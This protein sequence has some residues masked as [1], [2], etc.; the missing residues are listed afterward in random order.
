MRVPNFQQQ[1]AQNQTPS[2]RVQGGLSAG[3]AANMAESMY[4]GLAQGVK[5]AGNAYLDYHDEQDR[6]RVLDAKNQE[7]ELRM[8]LEMNDTDG[9]AKKRGVDVVNLDDGSGTGFVGYYDKAYQDGLAAIGERLSTPQQRQMFNAYAQQSNQQFK[10]RLQNYF[11]RENDTYQQ[12]VLSA[13]ADRNAMQMLEAPADFDK[14]DNG[15]GELRTAYFQQA[16]L[17]GKSAQEAELGYLNQVGLVHKEN[18]R[19][20][21]S[22]NNLQAATAYKERYAQEIPLKDEMALNQEIIQITQNQQVEKL[23]Q[24]ATRG[25]SPQSNAAFNVAP[26]AVKA[27]KELRQLP[28]EQLKNIKYTDPRLDSY[29]VEVAN[30]KNMQWAAPLIMGLR[31]AGE[32]SNNNQVS[33]V[34]ARSVMQFMPATWGDFNK[35]GQR[36]INNPADTIEAAY[37]FVDWVSK[38]YKTRDPMVIAA[39]YNGGGKAAQAV[40]NGKQ[41][42]A[43]ETQRYLQRMDGWLTEGMAKYAQSPS[44]ER[45][46]ALAQI[47]AANVSP[48]V[49]QKALASVDRHFNAQ[50]QIITARQNEQYE[51]NYK[52]II[53]GATSFEQLPVSALSELKPNQI[54]SLKAV[55]KQAYTKTETDPIKLSQIT[56]NAEKLFKGKPQTV[57]HQFADSLSATDYKA[58][59]KMYMEVNNPKNKAN[60]KD[61][62]YE[63]S[64]IETTKLLKPWLQ[65]LK[66]TDTKDE[67]QIA[68]LNAVKIDMM[69]SLREA[70]ARKGS[71][72]TW[73]EMNRVTLKNV[74]RMATFKYNKTFG[75]DVI[76]KNRV[77]AAVRS[78]DLIPKANLDKITQMFKSQGRNPEKVTE[79]EYLNAFYTMMRRGF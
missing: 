19:T 42:P 22:A 62:T 66:I 58:V 60:E 12:S 4:G 38:K 54:A 7:A 41:P 48:E 64:D 17:Q 47:E 65:Q 11:V 16:K 2:A 73:E 28:T 30:Q 35:G 61:K 43:G 79:T 21:L 27:S 51:Q 75:D 5:S 55:S 44:R 36:D 39:Y 57:L 34:G 29:T 20:L 3:Q 76:E 9:F 6:I 70:Q 49:K 40:I 50:D 10:G 8:H 56:L 15:R 72:L 24:A 37:E 14:I 53:S 26:V 67:Q 31:L 52:A 78:K 71:Q 46:A 23:V 13:T 33:P 1:V 18:V 45:E 63:V 32:R 74:G 25:T 68:H 59:T 77:Y 69:Q